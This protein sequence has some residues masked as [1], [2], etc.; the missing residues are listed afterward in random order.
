MDDFGTGYS[1]LR[2]LHSLPLDIVKLDKSFVSGIV[3]DS[4]DRAVVAAIVKLGNETNRGVIAEGVETD[5][6]HAELIALGC[7]EAQGFLYDIPRPAA[8]LSIESYALLRR[9]AM[10]SALRAARG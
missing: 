5:E 1:S 2:Y 7:E 3:A 10:T 8:E 6:Q 4:Q 9:P